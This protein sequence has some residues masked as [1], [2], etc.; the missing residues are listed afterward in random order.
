MKDQGYNQNDCSEALITADRWKTAESGC[1]ASAGL[2]SEHVFTS[3]IIYVELWQFQQA[4]ISNS[5]TWN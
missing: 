2:V 1:D 4:K 5:V 3:C